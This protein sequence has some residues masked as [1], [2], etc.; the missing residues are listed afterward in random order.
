M[1]LAIPKFATDKPSVGKCIS[2][3]K[4]EQVLAYSFSIK[5]L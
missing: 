5:K 4:I 3:A 2:S 1:N